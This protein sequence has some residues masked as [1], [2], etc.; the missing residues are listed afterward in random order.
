MRTDETRAA[1]DQNFL[2][3]FSNFKTENKICRLF[4][5]KSFVSPRKFAQRIVRG[6]EKVFAMQNRFR[7]PDK[8]FF[9]NFSGKTKRVTSEFFEEKCPERQIGLFR[10][11]IFFFRK[12]IPNF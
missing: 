11:D 3:H 6:L 9:E 12:F 10:E 7:I 5:A 4:S 1:G 2:G 8:I